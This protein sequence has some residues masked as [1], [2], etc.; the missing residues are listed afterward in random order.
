MDYITYTAQM[1]S[2]NGKQYL[3]VIDSANHQRGCN[4]KGVGADLFSKFQSW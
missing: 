1:I 3:D 2:E 4:P